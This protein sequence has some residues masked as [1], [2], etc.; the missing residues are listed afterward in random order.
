MSKTAPCGRCPKFAEIKTFALGQ[1]PRSKMDRGLHLIKIESVG[2]A[3]T[4][5]DV[6]EI[7]GPFK[8]REEAFGLLEPRGDSRKGNV[9]YFRAKFRKSSKSVKL[10]IAIAGNVVGLRFIW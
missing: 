7:I 2:G 8:L 10:A 9:G 1:W 6:G 5:G 4:R 3:N